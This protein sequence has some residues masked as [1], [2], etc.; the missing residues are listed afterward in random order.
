L[1]AAA[2]TKVGNIDKLHR[3]AQ[4]A[5]LR[6]NDFMAKVRSDNIDL[7]VV[8]SD[9]RQDFGKPAFNK[10]GEQ[11]S[12]VMPPGIGVYRW[13]LLWRAVNVGKMLHAANCDI[14]PGFKFATKNIG[15]ISGRNATCQI[16]LPRN[17]ETRGCSGACGCRRHPRVFFRTLL[18]SE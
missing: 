3:K 1:G 14:F 4:E 5:G 10:H 7:Q 16:Q 8:S 18:L 2:S 12:T 13:H 15:A 6:T 11:V 9:A 17:T